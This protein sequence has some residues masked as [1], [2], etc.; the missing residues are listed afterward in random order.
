VG[1]ELERLLKRIA[2]ALLKYLLPVREPSSVPPIHPRSILVIRQHNQLGDMLCVVPLLRAL[3]A[4]FPETSLSLLTS[5]VNDDIMK[6]LVYLDHVMLYDK[7]EFLS[8]GRLHP[9]PIIRYVKDLRRRQFDMVIVPATVSMSATSDLLAY[10]SGAPVRIGPGTIDGIENPNRG[11]YSM[12]MEL[13]WRGDQGRHQTLRNLDIAGRLELTIPDLRLEITL[14]EAE[15]ARG[16]EYLNGLTGGRRPILAFHP[17]AGKMPNRWPVER[18]VELA[19]W[20]SNELKAS[21][22]ITLG[23]MDLDLKKHLENGLGVEAQFVEGKA[24]RD[25]ASCV[26]G[27]DLLVSNDTG[28]MHVG[29]ATGVPVLSL[30][31]PTEPRQWSPLGEQNRFIQ[32]E[33]RDISDINIEQV[34]RQVLEMLNNK[35]RRPNTND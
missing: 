4:R 34:Q 16:R 7:R 20:A 3:K 6:G 23:P 26:G 29:A 25:V 30:F 17:G 19:R 8:R 18:F 9:L 32:P 33:S 35:A 13:D 28:I 31:G 21:I 5:P 12:P 2:S 27:V 10:V 22:V 14:T 11:L 24:I 15:R 1:R